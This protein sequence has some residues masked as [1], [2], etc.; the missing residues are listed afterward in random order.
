MSKKL[1][2]AAIVTGGVVGYMIAE[3]IVVNVISNYKSGVAWG[4][5]AKG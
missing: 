4:R 2:I 1:K 5:A 3:T